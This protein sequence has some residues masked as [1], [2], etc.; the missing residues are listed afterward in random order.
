MRI[1][2]AE[3]EKALSD[4][5]SGILKHNNYSVDAV[6]DGE[7][8]ADYLCSGSYDAAVLDVMM[9]KADG[10]YALK[11]AR[12]AGIKTPV[13]MLTAKSETEDKVKGLDS[14]A[15][16]YLTKPFA[17][18]E[19]LARLRALVRR[20]AEIVDNTV[21]YGDIKLDG[22]SYELVSRNNKLPLTAKEFQMMEMLMRNPS[23]IIPVETFMEKIWGFDSETDVNVVWTYASYLRKKLKIIGSSVKIKAIRN[24]GYT[25]ENGNA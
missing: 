16:D 20:P 1:L 4:A 14:G 18:A 24:I 15:D 10:F 8:A 11:T 22:I 9:P 13:L 3:D 19:L 17:A 12:A 2:L 25:L 6:Y 5:L 23:R 21:K 7:A